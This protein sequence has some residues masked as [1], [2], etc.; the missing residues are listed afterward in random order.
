MNEVNTLSNLQH[1]N[2]CKLLGFYARDG[3]ESEPRMLVYERLING[4]LDCLL[5]GKSDG[6]S[7]DWNARMKIAICVAQGLTFLHEEGPLQVIII[8]ILFECSV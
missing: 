3:C 1:P 4:S 5:F 2:L 8:N 7:I 6:P